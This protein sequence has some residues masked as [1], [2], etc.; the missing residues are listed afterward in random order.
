[1]PIR[2]RA[3]CLRLAG[4]V[5]LCPAISSLTHSQPAHS[6][7]LPPAQPAA[8]SAVP[9]RFS[10]TADW[11]RALPLRNHVPLW[12]NAHNNAGVATSEMT[13]TMVL[14]RSAQQQAALDQF[15]AD[16]KNP[17]SPDFHHWLTPAEFGQSFG[18]SA[19]DIQAITNWLQAQGLHINFVAP[20]RTFIGFSGSPSV[21]GHAFGTEVH[22]YDV[23][24][25][26]R[27][28]VSSDPLLPRPLAAVVKAIHGLYTINE[29][30]HH[31]LTQA[32]LAGPNLT[33]SA[34]N[35]FIAPADFQTIYDGAVSASGH[36]QTIGIVGRSR[37][38]FDDFRNFIA[39]TY[40]NFQLPTEIVPT[41]F[42]GVDPGPAYTTTPPSSV[43]L[44]EQSEATLDV[45]RAGSI[46]P[47]A[48]ILLVVATSASG[49][50]GDDAQYLVQTSPV[51]VQVM[52][53]S[54][55]ACESS[56][57]PSGVQYW[58]T[59]FEQAAA[60]G[61]SV[62][63]SSGDSGA[64]GCEQDFTTP[65]ANPPA[66]SP[67]YIC[68][69]SYATCVGGTEFNDAADPSQ[70]WGS[71]GTNLASAQKYI[72][73]G[74]WNDPTTSK[75][76]TQ[77]AGS[78]GGVSSIIPTPKWQTGTGIPSAR[79]GR[80]TP[81]V[82]FNGSCHTP[83]FACMAAVGASCTL[84]TQGSFYFLGFCGTSASAPSM[85]GVTA[86]L[87][88]EMQYAQGN[89]NPEIY[90]MAEN[91]PSSFHDTTPSSSGVATCDINTPSMCNNSTPGPT[92]LTGGQAGYA[93][94][95]GYDMVTGFGSLDIS[96]FITN[97]ATSLP[98]P[99]ITVTPSKTTMSP[100]DTLT[101]TVKAEGGS[102]NPVPTGTIQLTSWAYNAPDATPVN[103]SASFD[104]PAYTLPWGYAALE[105]SARYIPDAPSSPTYLGSTGTGSV[106]VNP[107]TPTV[108][109]DVSPTTLTTAQDLLLKISVTVPSGAPTPTGGIM[110]WGTGNGPIYSTNLTLSNGSVN[111]TI[112]AGNL[113]PGSVKIEAAYAEDPQSQ[114][115][116]QWG[117]AI[118]NVTITQATKTTP[119]VSATLSAANI[120]L[121]DQLIITIKMVP[122]SGSPT[123]TGTVTLTSGTNT[124]S[125]NLAAGIAQFT[126]TPGWLPLGTDQLA[127][128]YSGDYNTNTATGSTTVNVSKAVPASV[129]VTPSYT[130]I[131][132]NLDLNVHVV[133]NE[134]PNFFYPMG[135]VTLTSGTYT[136][137]P[138]NL[139]LK[140]ANITIPAGSLAIGT[141]TITATYSGSD[142]YLP[143]T[144]TTTV[145]VA[146]VP[147]SFSVAGDPVT[148]SSPGATIGNTS[149]VTISPVG[150][151]TGSVSLTASVTSSPAGAQDPP[152]VSFG[153]TTPVAIDGSGPVTATLTVTT[154]AA[155][156]SALVPPAPVRHN[157]HAAGETALGL[158]VLFGI[159]AR[160]RR[161]WC[162]WVS[163]LLLLAGVSIGFTAC[164]GGN[165]GGGSNPP[166][167]TNPGTTPGTY[168]VTITATSGSVVAT[169]TLNVKV[170]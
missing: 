54:Y 112:P 11:T 43:S 166:P 119:T 79:T 118:T 69:S 144:G 27:I 16:Q 103:G 167:V 31:S 82:S 115:F 90:A 128:S 104:I 157:W 89:I 68:S 30:P 60:E 52:S 26:A 13:L 70:Y 93:V 117:D 51:P 98:Q 134:A 77:V 33:L 101:I 147:A 107:I 139:N 41:A 136:S 56:A 75:G 3:F 6:R 154:T 95:T 55:G 78:G 73:E 40:A 7:P 129:V 38:N 155:S 99:A 83:Y 164:G 84:D 96:N 53:I 9:N 47:N 59:L 22:T 86:L 124:L 133:V 105:F 106:V 8:Q 142:S 37:T 20:S 145:T 62:F 113:P 28:S 67:N 97:F 152:T 149:K 34:G 116:Y 49:G 153:G 111:F 125:G 165:S 150:G 138:T 110:I 135:T 94:T 127:I 102:G 151:F 156:T 29:R 169:N 32:Q 88:E 141:D 121:A 48:N 65:A 120:T 64:S 45:T 66:I 163:L 132:S 18:L 114:R 10:T 123:P 140:D 91:Q 148:I 25:D 81:D 72:P 130:S 1:M 160:T 14:S 92:G 143:A 170:Q 109:L 5:L 159:P 85:A 162:T 137:A 168:V 15:L 2:F 39:R 19:S 146:T 80:Y 161:N 58:D 12:A 76:G 50:I 100:G 23:H 63:V 44:G 122:P 36:Q 35:N 17:A 57:G 71:N 158:L 61:I 131:M 24:G 21:V 74:G 4:F 87:D 108:N 126:T 46:A 42:G